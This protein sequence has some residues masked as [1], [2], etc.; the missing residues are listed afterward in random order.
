MSKENETTSDLISAFEAIGDDVLWLNAKWNVYKQLFAKSEA[1]INLLND[2][3][4]DFFQIV[5]DS[6]LYDIFLTISRL[7]DPAETGGWKNLT[8]R[9]LMGM[10]EAEGRSTLITE[11]TPV[12]ETIEEKC[13]PIRPWRNKLI[14]HKDF[15]S[16]LKY[17]PDPLPGVSR[18]MIE[19]ALAAIRQ[20]MGDLHMALKNAETEY[21]DVPLRGDG[22]QIVWYLKES[23][24]YH[25]H[26]ISGHVNSEA[27]GLDRSDED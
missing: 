5:H 19:E 12:L 6:V 23:R 3:A 7:T 9:R 13:K 20:Y 25:K 22:D 27:D 4:P 8:F 18:Q 14:A 11:L 2:F 17:E 10:L 24:A 16:G 15:G 21:A 1:R 26:R